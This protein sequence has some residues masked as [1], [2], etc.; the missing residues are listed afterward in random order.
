MVSVWYDDDVRLK[1]NYSAQN[2]TL[3]LNGNGCYRRTGIKGMHI[4]HCLLQHILQFAS[5]E[6]S[7]FH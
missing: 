1:E 6:N 7:E 4:P 3:T 2:T 5:A